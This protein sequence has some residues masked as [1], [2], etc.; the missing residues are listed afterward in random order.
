MHIKHIAVMVAALGTAG[1]T[2]NAAE[3]VAKNINHGRAGMQTVVRVEA[4]QPTIALSKQNQGVG[5]TANEEREVK[6]AHWYNPSRMP[7]N[8]T[9]HN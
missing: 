2:V 5:R 6:Q 8:V 3:L 7:V 4:E 1:L 9:A